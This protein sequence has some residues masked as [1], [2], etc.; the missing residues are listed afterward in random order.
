[1]RKPIREADAVVVETW[2]WMG[3]PVWEHDGIICTG[4][5]CQ[6]KVKLSFAKDTSLKDPAGLFNSMTIL[7]DPILF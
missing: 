1:M 4:E 5:S 7:F 6:V 2:K 3:T